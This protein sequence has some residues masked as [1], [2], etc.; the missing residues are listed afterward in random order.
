MSTL[1]SIRRPSDFP[2]DSPSPERQ[3]LAGVATPGRALLGTD[4]ALGTRL[5]H[6]VLLLEPFD[7]FTAVDPKSGRVRELH[8]EILVRQGF[9]RYHPDGSEPDRMPG[10][11]LHRVGSQL[12]LRDGRDDTWAYTSARVGTGW[13]AEARQPGGVLIVYGTLV[14]VRAPRGLVSTQ[15]GSRQRAAELSAGRA[16]GFVAAALVEWID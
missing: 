16:R 13:L 4:P 12:Q 11:A 7:A 1:A 3:L 15:Y 8:A 6:P 10:W 2:L 14:G 5:G 9:Q